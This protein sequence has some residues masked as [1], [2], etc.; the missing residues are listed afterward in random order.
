[1]QRIERLWSSQRCG[2]CRQTVGF[3][4]QGVSVEVPLWICSTSYL[5][6]VFV[7]MVIA[8][9]LIKLSDYCM[10]WIAVKR[11]PTTEH[12]CQT[13]KSSRVTARGYHLPHRASTRSP[14]GEDV[15]LSCSGGYSYP[16]WGVPLPYLG[17]PLARTG[18]PPPSEPGTGL[19]T[20]QVTGVGIPLPSPS[21]PLPLKGPGT[22]GYP[23][24]E[25]TWNQR[26]GGPP[27]NR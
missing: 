2:G 1:M 27:V 11:Q 23:P 26:P 20:G 24:S 14:V 7:L 8:M 6:I 3:G 10:A 18:V 5:Q 13:R 17:I 19:W 16:V 15:S 22:R 12:I 9:F 4:F 25:G 21:L